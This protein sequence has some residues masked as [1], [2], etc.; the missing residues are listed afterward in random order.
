MGLESVFSGKDRW[1][2]EDEARDVEDVEED[3]MEDKE[4]EDKEE[5][6]GEV[7]LL[8]ALLDG[9]GGMDDIV[10]E[11]VDGEEE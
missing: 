3:S 2:D 10:E 4:E 9:D 11:G 6:E 8:V 1:V 5:Y 7:P